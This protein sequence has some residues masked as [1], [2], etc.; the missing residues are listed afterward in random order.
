M[1]KWLRALKYCLLI[2]I[3]EGVS[4]IKKINSSSRTWERKE[5]PPRVVDTSGIVKIELLSHYLTISIISTRRE[6]F[7]TTKRW[8]RRNSDTFLL[9]NN[10]RKQETLIRCQTLIV[11]SLVSLLERHLARSVLPFK[12]TPTLRVRSLESPKER[13]KWPS[14]SNLWVNWKLERVSRFGFRLR[15]RLQ[16]SKRSKKHLLLW[17]RNLPV[18]LCLLPSQSIRQVS[19]S[20]S[21]DQI[22]T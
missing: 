11:L 10:L 12:I 5:V 9:T 13:R 14:P 15:W 18:R 3:W 22:F 2:R 7:T 4:L 21:G 6:L 16:K 8:T 19:C 20:G 1:F 17:S